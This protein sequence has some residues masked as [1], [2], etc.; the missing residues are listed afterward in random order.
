MV[1]NIYVSAE[2]SERL[3]KIQAFMAEQ[4]NDFGLRLEPSFGAIVAELCKKYC[5][6]EGVE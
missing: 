2:T 1:P 4:T 3:E 5:E 6:E